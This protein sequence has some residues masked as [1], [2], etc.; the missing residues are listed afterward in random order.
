M[1]EL[2]DILHAY[3]RGPGEG[4]QRREGAM[5]RLRAM[6]EEDKEVVGVTFVKGIVQ[7]LEGFLETDVNDA[8][9]QINE[10]GEDV[11]LTTWRQ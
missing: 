7:E 10:A 4:T 9:R 11:V 5:A 2:L 1:Q 3:T 8:E 6:S